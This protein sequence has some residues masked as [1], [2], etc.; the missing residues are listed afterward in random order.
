[1]PLLIKLSLWPITKDTDNPVNQ[2]K[3]EANTCSRHEARENVR[4]AIHD[5]LDEKVVQV[6]PSAVM[7]NQSKQGITF[8]SHTLSKEEQSRYIISC[9]KYKV[10]L[11][12][13][14]F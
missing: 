8:D 4:L 11:A 12:V 1:M 13:L 9:N 2:S 5:W 3:H 6:F 10:I 7:Q 14:F